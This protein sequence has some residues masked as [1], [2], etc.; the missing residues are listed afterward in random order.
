MHIVHTCSEIYSRF[1]LAPT[2][3]WGPMIRWGPETILGFPSSGSCGSIH[4][5]KVVLT[6]PLSHHKRLS[7][8]EV[9]RQTKKIIKIFHMQAGG[10][11][12]M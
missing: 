1:T 7:G 9:E 11:G 8:Y 5:V 4:L 2:V 6:N 10:G 12:I 3:R